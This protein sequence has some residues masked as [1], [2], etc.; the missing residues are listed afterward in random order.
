MQN[1]GIT[2]E[3]YY[4]KKKS[5][6]FF[7]SDFESVFAEQLPGKILNFDFYPRAVYLECKFWISRFAITH[8]Q[9]YRLVLR[10]L[11]QGKRDTRVSYASCLLTH[12]YFARLKTWR[13][14]AVGFLNLT[15]PAHSSR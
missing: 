3:W 9:T 1:K 13:T 7:S 10:G 4:D 12:G 8:V 5:L 2:L 6:P 11:D 15:A 14:C